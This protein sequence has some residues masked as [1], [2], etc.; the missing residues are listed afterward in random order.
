[1]S[2][3]TDY[4]S[5]VLE[6]CISAI[7]QLRVCYNDYGASQLFNE[8]RRTLKL[9]CQKLHLSTK[10]IDYE[11]DRLILNDHYNINVYVMFNGKLP[12]V[13]ANEQHL[14]LTREECSQRMRHLLE[15]CGYRVHTDSHKKTF[16]L[17]D[18][19]QHKVLRTMD[20]YLKSL[21]LTK[22][23]DQYETHLQKA[24]AK[25]QAQCLSQ[26]GI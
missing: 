24:L 1:M 7:T 11:A 21:F 20:D 9:A 22:E 8:N 4:T 3:S 14:L 5:A 2:I 25:R 15:D 16:W 13:I 6:N 10:P 18:I 23:F 19:C 17:Y 26:F 12:D